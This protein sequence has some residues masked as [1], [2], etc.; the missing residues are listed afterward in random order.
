MHE[1]T[2]IAFSHYVEKARWALDRFAVPYRD[3]RV[4]PVFH[5]LAVYRIHR[6]KLG[7]ADTAST[8]FSTPVLRTDRGDILCD[9]A[10]IIR[11][12]SDRFAPPSA[13]LYGAAGV[14]QLEQQFHDHLGPYS[15]RMVYG[16]LFADQKLLHAITRNNVGRIQAFAFRLA[17]PLVRVALRRVLGVDPVRVARAIDR[18]REQFD[19]VSA[20]LRDGRPFLLGDHFT[21]ADLAFACLAAPAVVPP[22]YSAWMPPLS[23]F[24]AEV[25]ARTAEFRQTLA[26]A[27]AL[28]MFAEERRRIVVTPAETARDAGH[29]HRNA[30]SS[31]LVSS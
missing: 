10:D 9:S 31:A 24:A 13:K 16:V 3:R 15:R 5:G 12:V 1:L 26:G 29:S 11:Y 8:R 7:R 18:V 4:L 30:P 6:G 21:A 28:R 25:R 19:A 14:E 27:F 22:E 20:L 23:D 2:G 17:Y